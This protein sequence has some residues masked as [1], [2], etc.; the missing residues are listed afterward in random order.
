MHDK[1]RAYL[2]QAGQQIR[3]KEARGPLQRELYSH[4]LD[5]KEAVQAQGKEE[6]EAVDYALKQMGDAVTVGT[7]LDRAHRPKMAWNILLPA[8]ALMM[9]AL[10]FMLYTGNMEPQAIIRYGI[11]V[12][13]G[14]AVMLLLYW[15]DFTALAK[16][17]LPLYGG[18]LAVL[19][20]SMIFYLPYLSIQYNGAF[21]YQRVL[22]A[23]LLPV[24]YA[25][26]V[27]QLRGRGLLG[28]LYCG[29]LGIL[30]VLVLFA[31]PA[32]GM[33]LLFG[34]VGVTAVFLGCCKGWFGKFG[35]LLRWITLV[36]AAV[37]V[38]AFLLPFMSTFRFM[39]IIN[40]ELDVW[41]NGYFG[42][43]L[44]QTLEGVNM[45]GH[46]AEPALLQGSEKVI[47]VQQ[48]LGGM[49]GDYPLNGLAHVAGWLPA[50]LV[51][52]VLVLLLVMM[53]RAALHQTGELGRLLAM[54]VALF[55]SLEMVIAL[56]N[57]VGLLLFAQTVPF[58][59]SGVRGLFAHCAILGVML[60]I[61]RRQNLP[62][63]QEK[64]ERIPPESTG[65]RYIRYEDGI[66]T[67]DIAGMLDKKTTQ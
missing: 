10:A 13:M 40:P 17:S 52:V 61:C 6:G 14:L 66:L 24:L 51:T 5:Q 23:P 3:W 43:L 59:T 62:W 44:R 32:M 11:A 34:I 49:W 9:A 58:F 37:P 41:G 60:S 16:W 20:L 46:G 48:V 15:W 19:F 18:L 26:C 30:G 67:I 54:A 65:R 27:Y 8:L 21:Y 35:R 33:A 4:I 31:I 36:C 63:K 55:F 42:T 38:A 29:A 1:I 39:T 57:N 45:L 22:F 12:V 53:W 50:L 2:E 28:W 7:G 56:L 25:G 47:C 64:T